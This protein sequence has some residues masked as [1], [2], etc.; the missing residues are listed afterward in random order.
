MNYIYN[1]FPH[2]LIRELAIDPL[3]PGGA[4]LQ[5]NYRKNI[6]FKWQSVNRDVCVC[7]YAA[8]FF[9]HLFWGGISPFLKSWGGILIQISGKGG[10]FLWNFTKKGEILMEFHKKVG[11][12]G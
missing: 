7:V 10:I 1:I 3:P 5:H 2:T 9:F 6:I 12:Y 4:S 11:F 8:V